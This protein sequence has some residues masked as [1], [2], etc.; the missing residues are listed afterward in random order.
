LLRLLVVPTMIREL[1]VSLTVRACVSHQRTVDLSMSNGALCNA[2]Q[3]GYA[4]FRYSL[5]CNM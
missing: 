2:Y 4:S 5:W 3:E 1:S